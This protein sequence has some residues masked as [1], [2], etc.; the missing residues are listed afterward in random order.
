MMCR[1]AAMVDRQMTNS[2]RS[3]APT[4]SRSQYPL[5]AECSGRSYAQLGRESFNYSVE[6]ETHTTD[7][8]NSVTAT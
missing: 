6:V 5:C 8:Q 2:R 3:S 7:L 4:N 1:R